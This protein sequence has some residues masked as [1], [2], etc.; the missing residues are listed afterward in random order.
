M[1]RQYTNKK[2]A[3]H[4]RI[5]KALERVG[6]AVIDLSDLKNDGFDILVSFR[7]NLFPVEIKN[8]DYLPKKFFVMDKAA[9]IQYMLDKMLTEQERSAYDKLQKTGNNLIIT[10]SAD[11]LL[12]EIGVYAKPFSTTNI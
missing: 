1:R 5:V 11:H 7:G 6:A 10:W 9:Q 12:R 8:P 4:A 2:D 3:N